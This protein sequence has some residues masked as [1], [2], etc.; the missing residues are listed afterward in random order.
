M[1]HKHL[2]LI[3]ASLFVLTSS[4][5]TSQK[6]QEK[7]ITGV[8]D[9]LPE[10]QQKLSPKAVLYVIA[11]KADEKTGPPVAVRRFTQPFVFPIEF[12]LTQQDA[13]IPDI[14]FEGNLTITA[15]VAQTGSATPVNP[16][17]IEGKTQK[18]T[19]AVGDQDLKISLNQV[20]K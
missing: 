16:G 5:C 6:N 17:D 18:E 9:I 10:L 14:P 19:V 20:R 11:R 2:P 12:T 7:K 1:T 13:M 8:I 3:I 4:A 15:R